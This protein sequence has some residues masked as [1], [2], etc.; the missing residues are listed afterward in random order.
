L[1]AVFFL[2]ILL[3][4]RIS[5]V[6]L[7]YKIHHTVYEYNSSILWL[8]LYIGL[9]YPKMYTICWI[10]LYVFQGFVYCCNDR[11][12]FHGSQVWSSTFAMNCRSHS[13]SLLFPVESTKSL[14]F[15]GSFLLW[16]QSGPSGLY[17]KLY[18]KMFMKVEQEQMRP[19]LWY[20]VN[21]LS[22]HVSRSIL[23]FI[24]IILKDHKQNS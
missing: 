23:P 5:F 18:V 10:L 16:S 4:W 24:T 6:E 19:F 11:I 1:N 15:F 17:L 22:I 21:C 14:R 2:G 7:Y 3:Y 8:I 13:F 20:T 9:N 12:S